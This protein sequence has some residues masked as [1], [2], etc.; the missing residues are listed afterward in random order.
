MASR[1]DTERPQLLRG[2][3]VLVDELVEIDGI[4]LAGVVA[5]DAVADVLDQRGELGLVVRAD[6][7]P[8]GATS[9]FGVGVISHGFP[10][11]STLRWS[12]RSSVPVDIPVGVV[13]AV[14]GGPYLLWLL[15]ARRRHKSTRDHAPWDRR[16][17]AERAAGFTH[18]RPQGMSNREI[19]QAL[20]ETTRTVQVQL[21]HAHQKLD[22]GS[23]THLTDRAAGA[24]RLTTRPGETPPARDT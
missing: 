9:G 3:L 23:R 18:G 14:I 11:A 12:D 8:S 17:H 15:A 16:T 24:D 20:L 21:T 19:D 5:S 10:V 13:T 1:A 6:S 22:I 7:S 2:L 4:D